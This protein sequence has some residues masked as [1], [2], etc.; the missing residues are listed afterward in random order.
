MAAQERLFANLRA[1]PPALTLLS[2]YLPTAFATVRSGAATSDPRDLVLAHI[3][4]TL[5]LYDGACHHDA[6]HPDV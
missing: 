3:A 1:V 2:Q 4:V 6:N 5:R